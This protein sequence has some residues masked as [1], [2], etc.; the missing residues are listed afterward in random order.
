L[1]SNSLSRAAFALAS[2]SALGAQTSFAA[3]S[4]TDAPIS[5]LHLIGFENVKPQSGGKLS[6]Q[7]DALVFHSRKS[8]GKVA[9]SS[10]DDVLLG[11]EATQAG[12]NAGK[13]FKVAAI[14]APYEAGKFL[15]V[16]MW[17]KVDV[18]TVLYRDGNGG[19]HSAVFEVPQGQAAAL[20]TQL[21]VDGTRASA[22]LAVVPAVQTASL[23]S[24]AQL[25]STHIQIEPPEAGGLSIPA[26][27]LF[28]GY[29]RL[30]E[31]VRRDGEFQKVF[32]S[33]DRDAK[34]VPDL[35][36][37]RTKVSRFKEGN[38][39]VRE[40]LN[41]FG[42]TSLDV[43]A[44]IEGRDGNVLLSQNLSGRVHFFGENLGVTNDLA[45]HI[46]KVLRENFLPA[47]AAAPA[48]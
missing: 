9:I 25:S 44:T 40:L 33:G 21:I 19:F 24:P 39:L 32:R 34:D 10:I 38:Q 15:S 5:A 8:E 30:I 36:V 6:I 3:A 29:E 42:W 43:T 18:L 27:Y 2:L 37:L 20:R 22:P 46:A 48:D 28:T 47:P 16:L 11:S 41:L 14:A 12:G 45:K 7:N 26:E 4:S 23:T 1:P 17:T 31:R 13:A 35:L